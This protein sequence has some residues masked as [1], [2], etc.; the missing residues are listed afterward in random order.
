MKFQCVFLYRIYDEIFCCSL[1]RLN[2][3][4]RN[5]AV[6]YETVKYE[7]MAQL[8]DDKALSEFGNATSRVKNFVVKFYQTLKL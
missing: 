2:D 1:E 7:C 5:I 6:K 4:T 3:A 8:S